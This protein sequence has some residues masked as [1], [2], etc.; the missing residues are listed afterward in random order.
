[1]SELPAAEVA[2]LEL[3]RAVAHSS[4]ETLRIVLSELGDD[5]LQVIAS[6]AYA[7]LDQ[8]DWRRFAAVEA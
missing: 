8:R 2:R 5:R 4:K 1:M 3:V 7:E 6:L